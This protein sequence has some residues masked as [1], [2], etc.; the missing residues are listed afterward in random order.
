MDRRI[1]AA[2]ALMA[3][4]AL[5]GCSYPTTVAVT[6]VVEDVAPGDG[7]GYDLTVN[8]TIEENSVDELTVSDVQVN[9]YSLDGERV[10]SKAYGDLSGS[11]ARTIRCGVFP[12]FLVVDTPDRGKEVETGFNRPNVSILTGSELYRGRA[13]GSHRFAYSREAFTDEEA[14]DPALADTRLEP[15]P[16]AYQTLQC[17]QWKAQASGA[18]FDTLEDTPWLEW[19]TRTPNRTR[20]YSVQV[21]N[22][23][24]L[25]QVN[26]TERVD[27]NP[28][29]NTYAASELPPRLKAKLRTHPDDGYERSS[30][31]ENEFRP[32]LAELSGTDVN[33]TDTVG[34][35]MRNVRGVAEEFDN[36]GI[37][38]SSTPP[39][40]GG[41]RGWYAK[42]FASHNGTTYQ[43]QLR[44]EE[45]VS[46]QAFENVTAP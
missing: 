41:T 19:D 28:R 32:I 40:Y 5:A 46:G 30:L 6:P 3:L 23:T 4:V 39:K 24:R 18:S 10:C 7:G 36:A 9:A 42:T 29:G 16:E 44:T 26:R 17:Q 22:Y 15:D 11:E 34:P 14:S 45:S 27:V 37:R 25:E 12:S 38:C 2:I 20:Q 13:N 35:A 21:I 8:V 31:D 33:S 1:P 43:I